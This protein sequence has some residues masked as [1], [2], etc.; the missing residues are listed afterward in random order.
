ME[1]ILYAYWLSNLDGIGNGT[2]RKLLEYTGSLE[3]IWKM[4]SAA[5][6]PPALKLTQ[7][8]RELI[9]SSRDETAVRKSYESMTDR[10]ILF[11]HRGHP[12]YPVRLGNIYDP[13]QGIY[14]R[15]RL[16]D[17][18]V[19][20]IAMVGARNCSEYGRLCARKIATLLGSAG[21]QI[22]SGMARGID[23]IAQ[24]AALCAGGYSCGVLGCGVDICYPEENRKLYD[25]LAASGGLI[26]EYHP[27]VMPQ[28]GQFPL[29][30]RIIS[31]LS[32]IVVVVEARERSGSLITAD[33]ALEQG[34]D[35]YAVPARIADTLSGGCNRLI[36]Q[37]AGII[38]SAEDFLNDISGYL[39]AKNNAADSSV[40]GA[41][42]TDPEAYYDTGTDPAVP[43]Q[44]TLPAA[45]A[46]SAD[47]KLLLDAMDY[48]PKS[49]S[50][51]Q[52]ET[53]FDTGR[54]Y[55]L[56]MQLSMKGCIL[57]KGGQYVLSGG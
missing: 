53:G 24:N 51:L 18:D 45:C 4:S 17:P 26:S 41:E 21:I 50:A 10:G 32:D 40:I 43:V 55:T 13:P 6:D 23:G 5:L 28:S 16:P 38:V 57:Q 25:S 29:R 54:M 44:L 20:S 30:N 56:L 9:L 14:V 37:G 42:I 7:R 27:G 49:V 31:A 36:R 19:M 2:V 52:R 8:A 22:I 11:Y 34:R 12:E 48:N 46:M 47:E 33:Q 39:T 3:E 15:G 35:V 1:D